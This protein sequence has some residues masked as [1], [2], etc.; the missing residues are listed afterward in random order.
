MGEFGTLTQISTIVPF[1]DQE[2]DAIR[3]DLL[4]REELFLDPTFP[5][6]DQLLPANSQHNGVE[7]LRPAVSSP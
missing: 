1:L 7:W 6:S 2:Y 3:E 5:A 4:S